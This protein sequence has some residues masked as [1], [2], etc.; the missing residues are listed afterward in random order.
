MVTV[1]SFASMLGTSIIDAWLSTSEFK[2][3]Y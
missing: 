2:V 1:C 3:G